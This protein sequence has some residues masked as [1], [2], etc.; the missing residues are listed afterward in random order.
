MKGWCW[1]HALI[2]SAGLVIVLLAGCGKKT[3]PVP[4]QTVL[5][6]P[7]KDLRYQL[8]EK[9]VTLKWSYP[10]RTAQGERLPYRLKGFAVYRAVLSEEDYCPGC[11]ITFEPPV[12]I[13]FDPL[14]EGKTIIYTEKLVHPKQRHVYQVRSKA[15][16]YITSRESNTVSFFWDTQPGAPTDLQIA[17]GDRTLSLN[18]QPPSSLVNGEP[19]SEPLFY[20]VYR[21]AANASFTPM[22]E[23]ISETS[24]TDDTVRNEIQYNYEVRAVRVVD[25]TKV[26]G[27]PSSVRNGTPK[28]RIAPAPP[29]HVT[30]VK[31]DEGV[32]VFWQA[33]TAADLGGYRIYRQALGM[34]VTQ[35][36]GEVDPSTLTFIDKRPLTG[37]TSWYYSVTAFDTAVPANESSFSTEAIFEITR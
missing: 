3:P 34:E 11:P 28:D 17:V 30:V 13:K 6:A 7:I 8:D 1:R 26:A 27:P 9:G 31:V 37:S 33:V 15:G 21:A 36:V 32:K 25:D 4:P 20:Q 12:G 23:I 35:F 29:Q 16:W 24:F 22:G 2:Y 14:A 5:P 19:V 10:N 18:W